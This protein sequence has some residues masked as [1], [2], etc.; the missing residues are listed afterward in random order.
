MSILNLK[1]PAHSYVIY[2]EKSNKKNGHENG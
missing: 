2:A 1:S